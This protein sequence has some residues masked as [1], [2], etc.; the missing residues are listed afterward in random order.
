MPSARVRDGL[1]ALLNLDPKLDVDDRINIVFSSVS[2][3]PVCLGL[4]SGWRK[5]RSLIDCRSLIHDKTFTPANYCAVRLQT[6]SIKDWLRS[7]GKKKNMNAADIHPS[8]NRSNVYLR[9][10]T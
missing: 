2:A 10:T 3:A 7:R 9:T 4:S 8:L 5:Y 6:S 1:K